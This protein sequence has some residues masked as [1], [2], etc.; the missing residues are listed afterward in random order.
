MYTHTHTVYWEERQ[1]CPSLRA[2]VSMGAAGEH[3]V[4]R[5]GRPDAEKVLLLIQQHCEK[6][7]FKAYNVKLID[8]MH[9]WNIMLGL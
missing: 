7:I 3:E 2:V 8:G 6:F 5:M 4:M 1:G 9:V